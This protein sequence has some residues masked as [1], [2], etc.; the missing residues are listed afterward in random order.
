MEDAKPARVRRLHNPEWNAADNLVTALIARGIWPA[1]STRILGY[2]CSD[3]TVIQ[4]LRDLGFVAYG[5]DLDHAAPPS[6]LIC[7]RQSAPDRTSAAHSYLAPSIYSAP[8]ESGWFNVIFSTFE[9]NYAVHPQFYLAD[10]ARLL[11]P[12]GVS[13]HIFTERDSLIEPRTFVPWGTRLHGGLWLSL[14]SL[15]GVR[16]EWQRGMSAM[17]VAESNRDYLTRMISYPSRDQIYQQCHRLFEETS[18]DADAYSSKMPLV[19]RLRSMPWSKPF[20]HLA[21]SRQVGLVICT[22]PRPSVVVELPLPPASAPAP[23][24]DSKT[25]TEAESQPTYLFERSPVLMGQ[26]DSSGRDAD[27]RAL[28][29]QEIGTFSRGPLPHTIAF[30]KMPEAAGLYAF[31]LG[32]DVVYVGAAHEGLQEHLSLYQQNA[33]LCRRVV[34]KI[35]N[36]LEQGRA[37]RIFACP[38]VDRQWNGL[39][40]NAIAGAEFGIATRFRPPWNIGTTVDNPQ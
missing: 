36:E 12:D 18:F 28:G 11:K 5:F 2:G 37:V 38:M 22:K 27:L 33:P 31:A 32:V 4:R 30:P 7:R 8:F 34:R 25:P 40:V 26:G 3:P 39:P 19:G 29:F 24:T 14:W 1:P 9:I 13:L 17:K 20:H 21:A 15:L 10:V 23:V 16:N 6:D 35:M